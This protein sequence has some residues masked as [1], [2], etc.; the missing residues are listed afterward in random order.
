MIS[1]LNS[2]GVRV[3]LSN[4]KSPTGTILRLDFSGQTVQKSAG[5]A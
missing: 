3:K 1:S 5:T 4:V 2:N